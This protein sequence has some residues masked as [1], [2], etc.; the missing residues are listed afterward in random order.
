MSS[1]HDH[2][3]LNASLGLIAAVDEAL[4]GIERNS[5]LSLLNGHAG[6]WVRVSSIVLDAVEAAVTAAELSDGLVDPTLMR[7][8]ERA[9]YLPRG[10]QTP[11]FAR[12]GAHTPR[13]PLSSDCAGCR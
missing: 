5:E 13:G 10:R 3:S 12:T 11:A 4:S 1:A 9:G 7:M 6:E 8:L 2:Q